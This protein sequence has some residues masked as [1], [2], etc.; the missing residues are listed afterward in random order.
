MLCRFS[1][2]SLVPFDLGIFATG[3]IAGFQAVGDPKPDRDGQREQTCHVGRWAVSWFLPSYSS[4]RSN[5]VSFQKS[6]IIFIPFWWHP[7]SIQTISLCLLL[8]YYFFLGFYFKSISTK[9]HGVCQNRGSHG[10]PR[11]G[12]SITGAA[13]PREVGKFQKHRRV[14]SALEAPIA[15]RAAV[16]EGQAEWARKSQT[17]TKSNLTLTPLGKFPKSTALCIFPRQTSGCNKR[18]LSPHVST[19]Y[20]ST[21]I[22][23]DFDKSLALET[24]LPAPLKLSC[25]YCAFTI[26]WYAKCTVDFPFPPVMCGKS[27]LRQLQIGGAFFPRK[28]FLWV[29]HLDKYAPERRFL[30]N[31]FWKPL[32]SSFQFSLPG[33]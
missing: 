19:C 13:C 17:W 24:M 8:L 28:G 33:E 25:R 3:F 11:F 32:F 20:V 2:N 31:S 22:A 14:T 29:G 18:N 27:P 9:Y 12:G 30:W 26:S 21:W 5:S 16:L 10:L 4:K 23:H 6:L 7:S 15:A 1:S